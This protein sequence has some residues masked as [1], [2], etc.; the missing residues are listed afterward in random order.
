MLSRL[1]LARLLACLLLSSGC[2]ASAPASP[3][4]DV[5]DVATVAAW[6]T[7][8]L[9][10][11]GAVDVPPPGVAAAGPPGTVAGADGGP[12]V[13][14]WLQRSLDAVSARAKDPP[15]SSRAYALVSVALH[16]AAVASAHWQLEHGRAA[17]PAYP[18]TE[19]AMAAAAALVLAELFPELP[20]ARLR[21]DA[22]AEGDAAVA[23]GLTDQDGADAGLALGRAVGEAVVTRAAADHTDRVWTGTPPTTPGSWAPPPGS[24]ARPTAPPHIDR[25]DLCRCRRADGGV[26]ALADHL[27]VL[28]DAPERRQ[29]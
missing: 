8:V 3:A 29:R 22:A 16:D 24:A 11:P 26:V 12:L 1:P 27:I 21:A 17:A 7:F 6:R 25:L 4:P 5:A 14:R 2:G 23:A 20:L 13:A 18:A 9:S 28:H 10:G 15:A 19:P